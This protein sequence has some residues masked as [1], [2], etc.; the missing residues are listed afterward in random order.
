[1]CSNIGFKIERFGETKEEEKIDIQDL[2]VS[3][4]VL[5]HMDTEDKLECNK[6]YKS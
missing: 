3:L 2:V 1:V 6:L 5:A 4:T